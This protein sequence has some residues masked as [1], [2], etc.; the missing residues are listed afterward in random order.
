MGVSPFQAWG[1]LFISKPRYTPLCFLHNRSYA[2]RGS[3]ANQSFPLPARSG[4]SKYSKRVS[5]ADRTTIGRLPLLTFLAVCLVESA[6]KQ[7][8]LA[9]ELTRVANSTLALPL[10]PHQYTT[11]A[12]F[13]GLS[14]DSPTAVVSAPGD[15]N[16]LFVVER[17]GRIQVITNLNNPNVSLFLDI[18]GHVSPRGEGGLLGLAFHPRHAANRYFFVFHT[19]ETT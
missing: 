6:A 1:L 17:S 9:A 11:V 5:M 14:F 19:L 16:R 7:R 18:S 12:A 3:S 8:I 13:P 10:E 15:T 4:I 2:T